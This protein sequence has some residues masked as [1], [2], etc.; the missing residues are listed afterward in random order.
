MFFDDGM[1]GIHRLRLTFHV[2]EIL[3]KFRQIRV[4][5]T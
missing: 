1:F 4:E 3:I 5:E 2:V